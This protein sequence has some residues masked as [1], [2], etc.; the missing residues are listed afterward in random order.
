[1]K[2]LILPEGRNLHSEENRAL[3]ASTLG[4]YRAME[5]GLIIEGMALKCDKKQGMLV[6]LGAFVGRIPW[7]DCATGLSDGRVRELSVLTRVGLPVSV[8]ITNI[9]HEDGF[10]VPILSRKKAQELAWTHLSALPCGSVIPVTA[11]RLE[12]FGAFV[13]MGCGLS[14]LIGLDRISVSRIPHPSAR[15]TVGQSLLA[16]IQSTDLDQFRIQLT[17]RELLGTWGENAS[18]FSVGSTVP[19]IIRSIKPYGTFIELTPNFSGL[20]EPAESHQEGERVSVYLK[21]IQPQHMKCKLLVIGT[22]PPAEP[23][24][25]RYYLPQNGRLDYWCYS[26]DDC[27][28]PKIE[29]YF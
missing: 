2:Q 11:T 4:L 6:E 5:S 24:P 25:L 22:L 10:L 13:D 12:A 21:S 7:E 9:I 16:V 23:C 8:V 19:A 3:C 27:I 20:A 28:R 26:P 29:K 14:S 18:I 1:M 17:H 15:F